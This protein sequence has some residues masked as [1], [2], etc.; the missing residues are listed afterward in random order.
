MF[1]NKKKGI[2]YIITILLLS[3]LMSIILFFLVD[4]IYDDSHESCDLI[5]YEIVDTCRGYQKSSIDVRNLGTVDFNF[6]F[7]D[8]LKNSVEILSGN[9]SKITIAQFESSQNEV[10]ILPFISINDTSYFCKKKTIFLEMKGT[11]KNC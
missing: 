8:D 7:N 10:S 11:F 5:D 6:I 9:S 4:L 3:I 1:N 2:V